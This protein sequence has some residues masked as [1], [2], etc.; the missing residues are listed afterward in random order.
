MPKALEDALRAEVEKRYPQ[1]TE[2]HKQRYIYGT[3]AKYEKR[4]KKGEKKHDQP[5]R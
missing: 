1:W 3:I 5:A 2:E 4:K